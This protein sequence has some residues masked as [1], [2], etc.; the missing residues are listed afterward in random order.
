MFADFEFYQQEYHGT[1]I[2][3][4]PSY[5]YYGGLA[6]EYIEQATFGRA[7]SANGDNLKKIKKCEC[8]LADI[9]A[10]NHEDGNESERE[11]KSESVGGWS[12]TFAENKRS[13]EALAS[14]IRSTLNL[15]LGLTGLLYSGIKKGV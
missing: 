15:Y 8:K 2:K 13:D 5:S 14:K 7:I 10:V 4:A 11:V 9:L 12:K 3:T 6:A 1:A